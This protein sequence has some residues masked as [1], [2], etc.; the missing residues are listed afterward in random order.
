MTV[1]LTWMIGGA[2]GSG[3]DTSASIF[4]NAVARAGYY[5]YGNRE[6]HSNI[7]GR[8]SY[9]NLTISDVKVNSLSD[10]VNILATFDAETVFQHFTEVKDYIIYDKALE[11]TKI[12]AVQSMEPERAEKIEKI[13]TSSGYGT[14]I[15]DAL[16]YAASKGVKIIPVDY[17]KIISE[18]ASELKLPVSVVERARNLIAS[19]VSLRLLGIKLDYL[20]AA[21]RVFFR[22]EL[23]VKMNERASEKSYD[24]VQPAYNLAEIPVKGHRVQLDGNTAVAIGKIAGGLRVQTYY[25]ITPA[26]D[27]SMFIEDN[28]VVD[29]IDPETKELRKAGV[30]VFQS[31]DELSAVNMAIGAALTGARAATATSG[32]GFSL[33]AEGIGWA[34]MNEAPVVITYYMRGAPS[35]GMPTR[36]QQ[37]DLLFAVNVSHGEFP[38][39]VIASGDHVEAFWDAIWALNL[40]ERYQTPVIHLVDKFLA[41]SYSIIDEEE[42][43]YRNKKIIDRGKLM[44]KEV[45]DYKRFE[46]TDDGISPRIPLGYAVMHYTGDEH[47]EYG[48]ITE[49]SENRIRMYEKRLKKLETADKEIPE[50]QRL[51]VYGDESDIAVVT[52]GSPKGPAVDALQELKSEGVNIQVIQVRMFNPYPR[53]LIRKLLEGKRMIIALEANYTAQAAQL[54]KLNTG[55]EPTHYVLK[56]NGRPITRTEVKWAIKHILSTNEKKV[57]LNGGA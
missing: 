18:V 7:K 37:A 8:H 51:R 44:L 9:F 56:W 45:D 35:T 43:D 4:G 38:R 3:V 34:G 46:F 2:Q 22:N 15:K 5:I 36:G 17:G 52:W 24:L 11:G 20:R 39:I 21:L 47:N 54:M 50:E 6:Y 23:Y 26:A 25:P 1:K 29:V 55:I 53:N 40:A 13:L 57:V 41:N 19:A 32:P 28:E 10:E 42:L 33:M 31:E 49:E 48:I 12:S 14:T 27:E 16:N 30:L